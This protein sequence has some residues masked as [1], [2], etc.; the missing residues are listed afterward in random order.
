MS[1]TELTCAC[2]ACGAEES[3]DALLH[4]M[5]DDDLAR[6]LIAEVIGLSLPLGGQVVS[7][8][9]LFKP[10]KQKLRLTKMREV[11][12]ELTPDLQRARITRSGR[13]WQAPLSIWADAFG[14]VAAAR[15]AG[16]LNLPLTGN[17]YLYQIVMRLSDTAEAA[18][19]SEREQSRRHPTIKTTVTT[20]SGVASVIDVVAAATTT[21]TT[22]T[23]KGPSAYARRVK[24]EIEAKLSRG[25]DITK[26]DAQ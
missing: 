13:E 10:A 8:L 11:L 23:T 22:V 5:I 24:A 7:Y 26:G 15:D 6:R 3:L 14:Q 17:G 16:T 12:T 2:S 20:A 21:A 9:R 1:T 18:V 4:R 25:I 19:E